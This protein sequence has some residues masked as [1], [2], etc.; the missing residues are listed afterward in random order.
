MAAVIS[1]V[2]PI[3]ILDPKVMV[4]SSIYT[5]PVLFLPHNVKIGLQERTFGKTTTHSQHHRTK[6]FVFTSMVSFT[7]KYVHNVCHSVQ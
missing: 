7:T 1:N 5:S 2:Y 4:F 3:T 6:L